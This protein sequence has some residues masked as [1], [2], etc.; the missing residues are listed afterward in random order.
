MP[1]VNGRGRQRYVRR[2]L[3][4]PP[5]PVSASQARSFRRAVNDTESR[6]HKTKAHHEEDESWLD[7]GLKLAKKYGPGILEALLAA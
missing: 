1:G 6:K 7:W 2:H 3:P 4:P 5:P